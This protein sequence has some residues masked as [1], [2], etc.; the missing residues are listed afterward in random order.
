[1]TGSIL[2]HGVPRRNTFVPATPRLSGYEQGKVLQRLGFSITVCATDE[3]ARG[4]MDEEAQ[5][6]GQTAR[7][8]VC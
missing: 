1:M 2:A 6:G 3:Q 4:Y 5:S 7:K 8:A